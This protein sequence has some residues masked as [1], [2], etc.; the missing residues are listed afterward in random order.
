M[1][2]LGL[3]V[4][5]HVFDLEY[6]I[7]FPRFLAI[8]ILI[9]VF[10]RRMIGVKK[11]GMFISIL[12]YDMFRF[13]VISLYLSKIDHDNCFIATKFCYNEVFFLNLAKKQQI[14]IL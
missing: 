14:P 7:L 4:I 9:I 8:N 6:I 10:L 12:I 2:H 3:L 11:E 13:I 5:L 1:L